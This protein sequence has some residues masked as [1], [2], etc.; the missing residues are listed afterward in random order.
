MNESIEATLK[1][2]T[3]HKAHDTCMT[4]EQCAEFLNV[5]KNTVKNR[6]HANGIKATLIGRVWR[7]PKMQFVKEIIEN[8]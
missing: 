5:H 6:I 2:L 8:Y 7:I 4:V 3:I 1:A